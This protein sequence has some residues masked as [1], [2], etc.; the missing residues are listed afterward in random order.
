[1]TL[2][3]LHASVRVRGAGE[4]GRGQVPGPGDENARQRGRRA[5]GRL[6]EHGALG[7]VLERPMAA[8]LSAT[9]RGL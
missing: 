9:T 8:L 2:P 5:R 1:M 3:G 6:I 4:T 7:I